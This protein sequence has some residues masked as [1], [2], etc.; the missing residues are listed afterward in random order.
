MFDKPKKKPEHE[1]PSAT[2]EKVEKKVQWKGGSTY[3]KVLHAIDPK[4]SAVKNTSIKS[5]IFK[6]ANSKE[7]SVRN[8]TENTA[9][10]DALRKK[11]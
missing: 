7:E 4:A 1:T 11:K 5:E 8:E 10:P 9:Q 6:K 2:E 3:N